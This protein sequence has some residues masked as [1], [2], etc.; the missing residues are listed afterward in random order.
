MLKN[1]TN[2][3]TD[4]HVIR[5]FLYNLYK[6]RCFVF[7]QE[8]GQLVPDGVLHPYPYHHSRLRPLCH[9]DRP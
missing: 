7:R 6:E 8:G 4:I 3:R 5:L 1:K 2:L 9:M